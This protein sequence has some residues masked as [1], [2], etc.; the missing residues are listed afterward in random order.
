M[1]VEHT[2]HIERRKGNTVYVRIAQQSA[3][4]SCEASGHCLAENKGE[5]IIEALTDEVSL[6]PGDTV[7]LTAHRHTG[8]KAVFL[9][10]VLPLLLMVGS[11]VLS[12]TLLFPSDETRAALLALLVPAVYYCLLLPFKRHLA[13]TFRFK[14]NALT[15]GH[16]STTNL[17]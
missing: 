13:G 10:Y 7:V 15:T 8:L 2:G 6:Q 4:G 16:F 3:C 14:A 12:L 9:A 17:P 5:A 11:M 1:L